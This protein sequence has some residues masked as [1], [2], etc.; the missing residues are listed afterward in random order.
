MNKELLNYIK[1]VKNDMSNFKLGCWYESQGHFSPASSFYLKCAENTE[2]ELLAYECFLRLYLCYRN[3]SGRDY[4]CEFLL[5]NAIQLMPKSPEAYF[6]ISQ[7]YEHKKNWGDSYLYACLG[8]SL[9]NNK[10]NLI[11]GVG[12]DSEYQLLFQKAVSAWWVG[13]PKE[14]RIIFRK[15]KDE[16]KD[17]INEFYKNL[18]Q[19]NLCSLGSGPEKESCLKYDKSKKLKIKFKE[20]EKVE[21]NFSQVCQDLFVLT[22]LNGKENGTYLEIGA[23]HSFHNS[24]TALLEKF[25][26][27]GVGIELKKRTCRYARKRKKKSCF[28]C[29]CVNFKL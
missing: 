20:Y 21:K 11:L 15:I 22:I 13:K 18:V 25:G 26:W 27:T 3:L 12:Y 23:A 17:V 8:L 14:A 29:R 19:N 28:T 6:L 16:Y 24:N 2:N 7:Y 9:P 5:K 1:D 10:S 4:T